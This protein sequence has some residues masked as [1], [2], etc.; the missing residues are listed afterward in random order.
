MRSFSPAQVVTLCSTALLVACTDGAVAPLSKPVTGASFSINTCAAAQGD[1]AQSMTTP[2][3]LAPVTI[4]A[5]FGGAG[6]PWNVM[7][8]MQFP[9]NSGADHAPCLNSPV[10]TYTAETLYVAKGDSI[11][12]PDGVDADWWAS[13]S[14]RERR[15][16]V[17]RARSLM[18]MYPDRWSRI[19]E[20]INTLFEGTMLR[21]KTKAMLRGIDYYG[22]SQEAELFA[23]GVYGCTLYQDFIADPRWAFSNAETLTLV[24]ELVTA[25]AEAQFWQT[26]LRA[27]V[28]GRNG[29]IGAA[30]ADASFDRE[31]CGS[32]IFSAIPGGRITVANPYSGQPGSPS[33]GT[34]HAPPLPPTSSP[35]DW[36]DQ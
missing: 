6:L 25:F 36:Y 32:M 19:G 1:R 15:V 17:S 22:D 29:T 7:Q 16:L 11:P 26:P 8:Q 12:A 2:P 14:A 34:P 21:D 31:D 5:N 24:I 3:S 13:L 30:I 9:L 28:F 23:G 20:A 33:G 4:T 18:E 10:V 35:P 27:L